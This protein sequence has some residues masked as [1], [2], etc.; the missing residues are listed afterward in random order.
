MR[1][2]RFISRLLLGV[3]TLLLLHA[4][5]PHVHGHAH[6][7]A[8]GTG[9]GGCGHHGA[10]LAHAH[11]AGDSW[12]SGMMLWVHDLVHHHEES[13][14]CD[15]LAEWFRPAQALQIGDERPEVGD[16]M[17]GVDGVEVGPLLGQIPGRQDLSDSGPRGDG[18]VAKSHWGRRGP[19]VVRC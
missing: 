3:Q 13:A 6:G 2:Q 1:V 10:H 19:P 5:V 12:W 18:G 11:A 8:Q 4:A 17:D 9:E 14:A 7:S 16:W 15:E